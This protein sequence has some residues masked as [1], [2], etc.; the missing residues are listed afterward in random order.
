MLM[1]FSTRGLA[2]MLAVVVIVYVFACTAGCA[3]PVPTAALPG[4]PAIRGG[5]QPQRT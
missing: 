5:D 4:E 3:T 1:P 2:R